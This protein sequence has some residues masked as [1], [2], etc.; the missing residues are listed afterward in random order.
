MNKSTRYSLGVRD[1]AILP[2]V[3]MEFMRAG[4]DYEYEVLAIEQSRHQTLSS[5]EFSTH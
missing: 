2:K 1:R 4:T 5:A 3:P